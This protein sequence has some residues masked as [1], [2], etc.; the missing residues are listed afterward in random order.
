MEGK[1]GTGRGKSQ[2]S[3]CHD[4]TFC[5]QKQPGVQEAD[6]LGLRAWRH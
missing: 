6:Q 5:A 4:R 1:I 3:V 2:K